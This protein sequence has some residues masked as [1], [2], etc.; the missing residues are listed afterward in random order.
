[1]DTYMPRLPRVLITAVAVCATTSVQ[2]LAQADHVRV[3]SGQIVGTTRDGIVSFKGIPYAA[4]PVGELRW[5]APR[6]PNSWK[7]PLNA[8]DYGPSC[9]QPQPV[10]RVPAGSRAE[11]TSED[12]LTL[13]VWTPVAR[14]HALPVM[15]WFHGGGNHDGTGSQTF[16]D[17]TAFARDGVVLVTFNYR[18]GALGFLAHPALSRAAGGEPLGNYG[19]LDQLAVLRWVKE[20][21]AAFGGDPRNVTACGESAGAEDIL[22]LMTT[23]ASAG[24]FHR[25]II[26]SAGGWSSLPPLSEAEITGSAFVSALK[27][28]GGKT[29]PAEM[30][31]LPLEALVNGPNTEV[32]GPAIDGR[33]LRE[34][35]AAVFARHR[36][37]PVRMIIGTNGNEGSLLGDDVRPTA[38]LGSELSEG[39]IAQLTK[40]YGA[41]AGDDHRLAR[42]LFRDGFFVAPSRWAAAHASAAA[43]V[44]QFDYVMSVLRARRAGA[45]HGSEIP[46]VFETGPLQSW[47]QTDKAISATLHS[48]W[49]AFA[50]TGKPGC[51][52]APAW[53][54]Y[55]DAHR[56]VMEFGE[57]VEVKPE[58]DRPVLDF[59]QSRLLPR[60]ALGGG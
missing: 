41:S 51:T 25:A 15:V 35:P 21:I 44:Y 54:E 45:N 30:R 20:N 2:A 8:V 11:H 17:G 49:V 33:L 9:P 36:A 3:S 27:L 5:R 42:V 18:L 10:R 14:T 40:L 22:V 26:E 31:A 13:N 59:L 56:V 39:D 37:M 47:N 55:G 12:C 34:Q 6:N 7:Q 50:T 23:Q 19:V 16:Y 32:F 53:P 60:S 28:N 1:M 58:A 24:L 43:F 29:T 38:A 46:F 57:P 48:C 52:G 4:P